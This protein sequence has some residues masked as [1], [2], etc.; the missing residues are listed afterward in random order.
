[1]NIIEIILLPVSVKILYCQDPLSIWFSEV[2]IIQEHWN[3]NNTKSNILYT[4]SFWRFHYPGLGKCC[5]LKFFLTQ[6]L[7]ICRTAREEGVEN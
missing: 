3:D 7:T 1:M 5:L 4:D 2:E 6:E